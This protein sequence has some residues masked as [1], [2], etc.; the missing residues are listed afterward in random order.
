MLRVDDRESTGDGYGSGVLGWSQG[1][2]V[3]HA[4]NRNDFGTDEETSLLDAPQ[5]GEDALAGGLSDERAVEGGFG[6]FGGE[7]KGL[8]RPDRTFILLT[9]E[10]SIRP[11]HSVAGSV[12]THESLLSLQTGHT[13][14]LPPKH[15]SIFLP[16]DRIQQC[17][18]LVVRILV[19]T[20]VTAESPID[21]GGTGVTGGTGVEDEGEVLMGR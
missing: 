8:E 9:L 11:L 16:L 18:E 2:G 1:R 7:G 14:L 13:P 15:P 20:G 6:D 12:I 21:G 5:G 3:P 4:R 17:L 10:V 19:Q